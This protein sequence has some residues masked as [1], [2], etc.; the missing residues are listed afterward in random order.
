MS[1]TNLV[2]CLPKDRQS[3]L[4]IGVGFLLALFLACEDSA[5]AQ[6]VQVAGENPGALLGTPAQL[7]AGEPSRATSRRLL[8]QY[9]QKGEPSPSDLSKDSDDKRDQKSEDAETEDKQVDAEKS[10]GQSDITDSTKTDTDKAITPRQSAELKLKVD[11]VDVSTRTIGR[12]IL[13]GTVPEDTAAKRA[14]PVTALLD[15]QSRGIV[16]KQVNWRPA[17]ISHFPLYFEDAMLERHGHVRW[18]C[19]QPLVSGAKFLTTIPLLPYISTLQP[20]CEPR[21]TL[22]HFRPGSCAPALKDHLPWDRRAAV[23]ETVSLGAFFWA[24][25]L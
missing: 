10:E 2:N 3:R 9:P 19:A 17:N 25:P 8:A 6:V 16:A 13:K 5:N 4:G 22:G 23:V 20:K 1:D 18:G 24:A 11:R 15:G 21:Y 12:G 14:L 7:V